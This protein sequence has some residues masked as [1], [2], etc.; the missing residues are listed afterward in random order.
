M[1]SDFIQ[2]SK[3][4]ATKLNFIMH[5]RNERPP[6]PSSYEQTQETMALLKIL[7][8]G[9]RQI[10]EGKVQ[11]AEEVIKHLRERPEDH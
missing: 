4:I 1:R 6:L 11:P 10:E 2:V 8:L 7:A 5:V 3:S 9:T